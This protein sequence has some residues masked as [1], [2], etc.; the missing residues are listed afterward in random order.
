MINIKS[1]E[2]YHIITKDK[3]KILKNKQDIENRDKTL[4]KLNM[5]FED[6]EESVKEFL[7]IDFNNE[8]LKC[9][10]ELKEELKI[11]L[12]KELQQEFVY[13]YSDILKN[14][15]TKLTEL[16]FIVN[17]D[18]QNLIINWHHSK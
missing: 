15:K 13:I 18:T 9:C 2:Y 1:A 12:P 3:F 16:G 14:F 5:S 17:C 4:K 7:N 11:E 6:L 8:I 10:N